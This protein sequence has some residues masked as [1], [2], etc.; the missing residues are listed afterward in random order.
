MVH[1]FE[2]TEGFGEILADERKNAIADRVW[3][4]GR[5]KNQRLSFL[6]ALKTHRGVV[7]DADAISSFADS[8]EHLFNAIAGPC[9]LTPHE[10]EVAHL[11]NFTGDK[12]GRAKKAL[13]MSQ[14]NTSA[15]C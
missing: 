8:P 15:S 4:G 1:R 11:F 2:G 13:V 6:A 7:I 3:R 14:E 12:L 10:G 5:I 9:V